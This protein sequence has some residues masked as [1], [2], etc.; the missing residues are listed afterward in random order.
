MQSTVPLTPAE[1]AIADKIWLDQRDHT[2]S[3]VEKLI[4]KK[5]VNENGEVWTN[6][7]AEEDGY[8]L[9]VH[10]QFA[11]RLLE[12]WMW[13]TDIVSFTDFANF[14][15]LRWSPEAEPSMEKITGLAIDALA[16]STPQ[17][18]KKGAW[19]LPL[20]FPEDYDMLQKEEITFEDLI[21]ISVGRC[22]RVSYLTHDGKRDLQADIDLHDRLLK[23][24]HMSP[25]EHQA[26]ALN[27]KVK[28]S[29]NFV[30]FEQYRKLL[31]KENRSYFEVNQPNRVLKWER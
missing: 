28:R 3:E 5:I 30:G 7:A 1:A 26:F 23:N 25:F 22:A 9:E 8:K 31:P 16:K 4:G 20:I 10:K 21:K 14:L 29:G 27:S 18:L 6:I 15:N 12:P 13:V 2:I 24:G 17:K 11:N 19:H